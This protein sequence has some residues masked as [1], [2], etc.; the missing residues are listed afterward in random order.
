[1]DRF[2]CRR[3]IGMQTEHALIRAAYHIDPFN[4]QMGSNL[5]FSLCRNALRKLCLVIEAKT[6]EDLSVMLLLHKFIYRE[7]VLIPLFLVHKPSI[8]EKL[9]T[10]K[11]LCSRLK[12]D[13]MN[14]PVST[15]RYY[16]IFC[17]LFTPLPRKFF[18]CPPIPSFPLPLPAIP[19]SSFFV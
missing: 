7:T 1:M 3:I 10:L 16:D 15:S 18:L 4:P 12:K 9:P 14:V 13:D 2:P 8:R 17:P 5:L 19:L 11:V 6:T